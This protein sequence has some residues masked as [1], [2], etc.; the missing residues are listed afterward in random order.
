MLTIII[1]MMIIDLYKKFFFEKSETET[2]VL[3]ICYEHSQTHS[4]SDIVI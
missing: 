3:E 2:E 4:Y 1:I